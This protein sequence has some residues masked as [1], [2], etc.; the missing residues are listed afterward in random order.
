MG[1]VVRRGALGP[2]GSS[3]RQT[4]DAAAHH[5]SW[6]VPSSTTVIAYHQDEG[7]PSQRQ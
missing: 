2:E 3:S 4:I 5:S 7:E 6:L 1:L